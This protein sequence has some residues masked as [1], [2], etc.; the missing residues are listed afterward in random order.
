MIREGEKEKRE[1]PTQ[2]PIKMLASV[3]RDFSKK[4]DLVV[5]TFGGAGS[6]LIAAEQ[7]GRTCYMME[8]SP[9]YCDVIRK[10]YDNFVNSK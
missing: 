1:H 10:R 4:D 8:I 7:T 3:L 6:T 5:D 2:K 9:K